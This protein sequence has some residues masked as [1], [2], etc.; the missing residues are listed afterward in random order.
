MVVIAEARADRQFA[1][2]VIVTS[3]F[4]LSDGTHQMHPLS[5]RMKSRLLLKAAR[6]P[7]PTPT[8]VN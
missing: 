2:D 6:L 4:G 5:T 1:E 3:Q 7:V 8:L